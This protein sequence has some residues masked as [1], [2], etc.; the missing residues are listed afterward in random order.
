MTKKQR[1][2]Q[3]TWVWLWVWTRVRCE[4]AVIPPR[5]VN[6]TLNPCAKKSWQLLYWPEDNSCYQIFTQGPCND[7]QEFYYNL[8]SGKGA[9]RCPRDKV[10]HRPTGL[11]FDEY[12]KGP[13]PP[14]QFLAGREESNIGICQDFL[15]C[16]PRH[17]FWPRNNKC[18]ELH[19][20]GPC[21]NGYLLYINP[22]T[23]FPDCGCDK[24]L[25]FSNYW[26]LTGLCFELFKRGPCLEGNIFLYNA[27][28]GSTQCSCSSS[29]LTNYH[30][31][32]NGCYELNHQGPCNPGQIFN[33]DPHVMVTA[34]GCRQDHALWPLNGHCYRIYSKGPCEKGHF[35]ISTTNLT[36]PTGECSPYPCT[37]TSRYYPET[38]ECYK[39]GWR[40][41]CPEGQ[42]FIYD[43]ESPLRGTCGCTEELIGY[44]PE[45]AKCYELGGTGPCQHS[46]VLSYEKA[47]GRVHCT[48]DLKKGYV[49]WQD[50]HCYRLESR[51]P[52]STGEIL[53]VKRWRPVT[54][55]C[56]SVNSPVVPNSPL[57]VGHKEI[58]DGSPGPHPIEESNNVEAA[59]VDSTITLGTL[60]DTIT[61]DNTTIPSNHR[62]AKSLAPESGSQNQQFRPAPTNI[63]SL[64]EMDSTHTN[65]EEETIYTQR[66]G[67][68]MGNSETWGLLD[69]SYFKI[70]GEDT[71][72]YFTGRPDGAR[73]LT[74]WWGQLPSSR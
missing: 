26:S 74:P 11:C 12:S 4:G 38:N 59:R 36:D 7:T 6:A 32:S 49:K 43:E 39:L 46:Q 9:C 62:S 42:L 15:E 48:C 55:I 50:G 21:L 65:D 33:F 41:P 35:F 23:G 13:C 60:N 3:W 17:V 52:C 28:K 18:Y 19:T 53:T 68:S 10:L 14:R 58:K 2:W 16:P 69:S 73:S 72:I 71:E 1:L 37:G 51:G 24:N 5:W 61:S 64:G 70:P 40:G 47:T 31:H 67:R 25:M 63:Y 30:N 57:L 27:T 45:D 20:Q 66:S 8:S 22:A 44:W 54:P 29:I 56:T 34:C